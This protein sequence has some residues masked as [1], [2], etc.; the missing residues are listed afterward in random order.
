MALALR[1]KEADQL[2]H[3]RQPY[4]GRVGAQQGIAEGQVRRARC[5]QRYVGQVADVSINRLTRLGRDPR[6]AAARAM[7]RLQRKFNRSSVDWCRVEMNRSI[8]QHLSNL[9][10]PDLSAVEIS[11][12]EIIRQHEWSA[13]KILEYPFFDLCA[14]IIPSEKFDVVICSQVLEHVI[15]PIAAC[16]SLAALC[17]PGGM[18]VVATPFLLRVHEAPLDLW[19]FTEEGL[20]RLLDAGGLDVIESHSWGNAACVRANLFRWAP[21]APWRSLRNDPALPVVVWAFAQPKIGG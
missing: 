19:R 3:R 12:S 5:G 14:P 1:K 9:A 18:V 11:G 10:T 21:W 16:R 20:S 7:L 8:R 2:T 4:Q 17:A 15:D 13:S 6:R